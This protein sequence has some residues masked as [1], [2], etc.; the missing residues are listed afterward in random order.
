MAVRGAP[1]L[2]IAGAL[3]LAAELSNAPGL[4][5]D[6]AGMAAYVAQRAAVRGDLTVAM[7]LADMRGLL[8]TRTG[9][10]PTPRKRC[11]GLPEA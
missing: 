7:A 9:R 8:V 5:A 11:E 10:R 3:G 6:A 2:A 4:P 1:A